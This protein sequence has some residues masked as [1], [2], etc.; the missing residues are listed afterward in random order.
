M[1]TILRLT[2]LWLFYILFSPF[3]WCF[4]ICTKQ[5]RNEK[6]KS[7]WWK[8]LFEDTSVL[9]CLSIKIWLYISD[10][11]KCY[12]VWL[13]SFKVFRHKFHE[14]CL[15]IF[16]LNTYVK[17]I[18]RNKINAFKTYVKNIIWKLF[19]TR[20]HSDEKPA[21]IFTIKEFHKQFL[22]NNKKLFSHL[23][24]TIFLQLSILLSFCTRK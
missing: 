6:L 4:Y 1:F 2:N 14:M 5:F 9:F 11:I 21:L 18:I 23:I 22:S 17:L 8:N 13:S 3:T 7:E 12:S 20:A 24:K 10:S 19:I 15:R 16:F